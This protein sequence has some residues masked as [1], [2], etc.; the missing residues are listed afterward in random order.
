MD[1]PPTVSFTAFADMWPR[2]IETEIG[3]ALCAFG[4]GGTLPFLVAFLCPCSVPLLL[5]YEWLHFKAATID[6]LLC[7]VWEP[8]Q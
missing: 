7:T 6:H 8:F 4:A 1:Q 5:L 2:A 3:A